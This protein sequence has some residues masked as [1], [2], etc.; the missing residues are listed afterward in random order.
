MCSI[1]YMP[2]SNSDIPLDYPFRVDAE[3][4][5]VIM[6][7]RSSGPKYQL[8]LVDKILSF[9]VIGGG[10][11]IQELYFLFD[12]GVKIDF[13]VMPNS[14]YAVDYEFRDAEWWK[15]NITIDFN[16]NTFA[17]GKRTEPFSLLRV[18]PTQK[19]LED[20]GLK[21]LPFTLSW[22]FYN[23]TYYTTVF[24]RKYVLL[25]AANRPRTT[26]TTTTTTTTPSTTT[27]TTTTTS[28]MTT[29]STTKKTATVVTIFATT[30]MQPNTMSTLAVADSP[31]SSR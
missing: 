21:V 30:G 19:Y 13:S 27:S 11:F 28:T 17:C 24:P 10:Y 6:N 16:K 29:T 20:G 5:T 18:K 2:L 7:A 15:I 12:G 3:N 22:K 1:Y 8:A 9:F 14:C 31:V 4:I 26:T 23:N 25:P